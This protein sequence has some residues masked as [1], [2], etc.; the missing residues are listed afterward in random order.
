MSLG[1]TPPEPGAL[2]A[3]AAPHATP[4]AFHALLAAAGSGGTPPVL[5]DVRNVYETR[6]GR[7]Q[8]VGAGPA[9]ASPA[10]MRPGLHAALLPALRS[11]GLR[12]RRVPQQARRAP[13]FLSCDDCS[14][15]PSVLLVPATTQEAS[16][17][18][19]RLLESHDGQIRSGT[20]R[21]PVLWTSHACGVR[22]QAGVAT[23]DPRIRC[24]SDLRAWLDAAAPDLAGRRVLMYCTGARA[25]ALRWALRVVKGPVA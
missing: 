8:A 20:T 19:L 23:L 5:L 15:Q 14:G 25:R 11:P 12:G 21:L 16:P 24:F 7:M 13:G 6:I 3:A 4:Q 1:G 18:A 9:P 2:A 10:C 22:L 17:M